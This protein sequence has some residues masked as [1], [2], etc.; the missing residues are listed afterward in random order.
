[1]AAL[2]RTLFKLGDQSAS[3]TFNIDNAA[4]QTLSRRAEHRWP[5]QD[6]LWNDPAIQYTGAGAE[7][8]DLEAEIL[9]AHRG[10]GVGQV[11]A[12]RQLARLPVGNPEPRPLL[13]VTGYGEVLGQWCI[14]NIEETQ[15]PIGPEG[16]PLAQRVR[17]SLQRYYDDEGN[18]A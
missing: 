9:P 16:A 7:T 14:L 10:T 17:L 18:A 12:L 11:E 4:A 2:S 15:D 5:A 6:R 3:F 13:L 8:L 1:M